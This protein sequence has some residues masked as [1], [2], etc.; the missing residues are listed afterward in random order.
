[1]EDK[2][3]LYKWSIVRDL[4]FMKGAMSRINKDTGEE[5]RNRNEY[6]MFTYPN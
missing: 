5:R 2:G 6:I 3:L 1:M 4:S